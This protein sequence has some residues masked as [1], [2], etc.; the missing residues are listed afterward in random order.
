MT[1]V[2]MAGWSSAAHDTVLQNKLPR[3]S[4]TGLNRR[5][6]LVLMPLPRQCGEAYYSSMRIWCIKSHG[7]LVGGVRQQHRRTTCVALTFSTIHSDHITHIQVPT[8]DLATHMP[9]VRN[10]SD[11]AP[12]VPEPKEGQCACLGRGTANP[13]HQPNPKSPIGMRLAARNLRATAAS[14]SHLSP[15]HSPACQVCFLLALV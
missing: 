11:L 4:G 1:I 6:V 15:P 3:T 7:T 12:N 5:D 10:C 13:P 2:Y 9:K 14:R 8:I